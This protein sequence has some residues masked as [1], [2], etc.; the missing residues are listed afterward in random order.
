M[1]LF[2][3]YYFLKSRPI[4]EQYSLILAISHKHRSIKIQQQ[5]IT[6]LFVLFWSPQETKS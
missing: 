3:K 5:P 6:S 2:I 1:A 4:H